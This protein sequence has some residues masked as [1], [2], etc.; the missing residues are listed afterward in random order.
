MSV[1]KRT[2]F[3]LPNPGPYIAIVQSHLDPTYMG[4]VEA[5]LVQGAGIANKPPYDKSQT[6]VL[7]YLSPFYGVTSSEFQ[8]K[9]PTEFNDVQKSYGMWMIPPDIGTRVMCIFIDGDT[10]QGYWIGCVQDRWQNHMV[11]GIAAST[12]VA[13]K[14]GEQAKY[15]VSF[16]P[17]AEFLKTDES[18]RQPQKLHSSPKPVHPFA[19]VL[20]KQGLLADTIRGPSSSSA[21][22]EVPSAVFG[23]STPGQVQLTGRKAIVGYKNKNTFE[24]PISR[25]GGHT[26]V[27]DDG[28]VNGNNN[29]VRIRSSAGHQI[30]LHDTQNLIY[31]GNADGTSW[32]EMTAQGKIDIFAQDSVSIHTEADFNFRADRDINLEAVRNIN[33]KAG[34]NFTLNAGND[35]NLRAGVTGKI[36]VDGA[37]ES[38]AKTD[39]KLTA[40]NIH[41]YSL[42]KINLLSTK[43]GTNVMVY[44]GEYKVTAS[45]IHHNGP[46][47]EDAD[48][49]AEAIQNTT[50]LTDYAIPAT[51][52]GAN[53]S[54]RYSSGEAVSF[55]QRVPMHEPWSQH[56]NLDPTKYTA[57]NTD[58]SASRVPS[59]SGS[60]TGSTSGSGVNEP[61]PGT[62]P[63][64]PPDWTKDTGFLNRVKALATKFNADYLDFL[65]VMLLETASTMSPSI[66]NP[67]GSATGLI[68]FI[69]S[70][71]KGLG[72]TTRQ[73]ATMTREQQMHYVEEYF[74]R[75]YNQLIK[76]P[77]LNNIYMA[78]FSPATVG[79]PD[80]SPLYTRSQGRN[81]SDNIEYDR[82]GDGVITK[83]EA[84]SALPTFKKKVKKALGIS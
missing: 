28:D 19:D 49:A 77:S 55:L 9:D 37:L 31:I 4:G 32:I 81:Y 33:V 78:V 27:M 39:L 47:A 66:R 30:L 8:G 53:W 60:G 52:S 50:K 45:T 59:S 18:E 48:Y 84:C 34:N 64:T 69:E 6:V 10:N 72:T 15:G 46:K 38:Y 11:P 56:E 79:K 20:A 7:H 17:V 13:W 62:N 16:L 57:T 61:V 76:D 5:I 26:F 29:L 83:A 36:F 63:N 44:D 73:L 82:N 3:K 68:Q 35:F 23:I 80:N 24:V 22:R 54:D 14:P 41:Q 70:T 71:A 42:G 67:R 2:P 12:D 40:G 58:S 43:G 25:K 21:R 1:I 65:T 75:Q 51:S 74:N